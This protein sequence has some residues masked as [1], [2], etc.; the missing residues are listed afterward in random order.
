MPTRFP[1]TNVAADDRTSAR[2]LGEAHGVDASLVVRAQSGDRTAEEAIYRRHVRYIGGLVIRLLGDRA[3]AEDCVQETFAI[4][5]GRIGSLRDG[6]ALR[7]W[8][9]Q[10]SVNLV[11]RRFRRRR[12]MRIFGIVHV[13]DESVLEATVWRGAGPDVH[14]EL[15]KLWRVLE[16]LPMDERLAWSLR[17]VEGYS[18]DEVASACDCSLATAKRRIGA[19]E[20]SVRTRLRVEVAS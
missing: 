11:R 12:L 9:A 15:A 14:V 5:L 19:A 3:E 7:G 6:D 1:M 13:V 4:A 8:I 2:F 16:T 20:S 18:L 10:I 17:H